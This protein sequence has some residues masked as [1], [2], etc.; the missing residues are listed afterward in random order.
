[1]RGRLVRL[2]G[3]SLRLHLFDRLGHGDDPLCTFHMQ[4]LDQLAVDDDNALAARACRGMRF[5]DLARPIDIG[6]VR[7]EY[8]VAARHLL[9]VDQRLAVETEFRSLP[10]GKVETGLGSR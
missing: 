3:G 6:G 4:I 2:R 7:R 10:A 9:R 8:L 5:D 1:M